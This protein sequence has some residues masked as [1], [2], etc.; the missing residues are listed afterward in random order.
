MPTGYTADVQ[1]GKLTEFK[2]FALRCARGLSILGVLRDEPLDAPIPETFT[3]SSY[4][5]VQLAESK[6]EYA[7][8]EALSDAEIEQNCLAAYESAMK[9]HRARVEQKKLERKRY[10]T[11]IAK[12]WAWE[13]PSPD[14]EYLKDF[15]RTQLVESLE[16]DCDLGLS[17][18][19]LM[20]ASDWKKSMLESV[21]WSI[22]YHTKQIAEETE[23]N[24][25]RTEWV[26]L[27]RESLA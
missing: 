13:P 22:D 7:R 24:N 1:S 25:K 10:E 18:P 26:R 4:H 15:M 3:I 2:D 12:V 5:A 6:A 11:M 14:H 9:E 21:Q 16:H 8:L 19:K 17:E 23:R 20:S 27:L